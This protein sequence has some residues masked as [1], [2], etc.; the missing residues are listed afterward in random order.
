MDEKVHL[1]KKKKLKKKL[2][3]TNEFKALKVENSDK[4]SNKLE[5]PREFS[6]SF[7]FGRCIILCF[8]INLDWIYD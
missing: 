3:S 7:T 6:F 1:K 2:I 8:D 4:Y 5:Q